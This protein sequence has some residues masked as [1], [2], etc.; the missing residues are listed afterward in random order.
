MSFATRLT[1]TQLEDARMEHEKNLAEKCKP[2]LD[3][4]RQKIQSKWYKC[5]DSILKSLREG[6]KSTTDAEQCS[7]S[8]DQTLSELE[9]TCF[10]HLKKKLPYG[11]EIKILDN[12]LY[13]PKSPQQ[14]YMKIYFED[15]VMPLYDRL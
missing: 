14:I 7:V 4:Y 3:L 8:S 15:A 6:E 11:T 13:D 10:E 1:W 9:S 2:V 12:G 5:Q